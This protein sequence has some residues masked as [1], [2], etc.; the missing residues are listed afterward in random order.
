MHKAFELAF[1]TAYTFAGIVPSFLEVDHVDFYKP[2]STII[3]SFE[4]T[5]LRLS[6]F[7]FVV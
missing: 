6:N 4:T 2:V 3:L 5:F 7:I 1:S